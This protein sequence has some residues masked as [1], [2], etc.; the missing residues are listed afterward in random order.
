M[1]KPSAALPPARV[2][3]ETTGTVT[4]RHG[5]SIVIG[6]GT[7]WCA[8]MFGGRFHCDRR[9]VG[10]LAAAPG[11]LT[12]LKPWDGPDIAGAAYEIRYRNDHAPH[13]V[14][15]KDAMAVMAPHIKVTP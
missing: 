8:D 2:Q 13:V 15:I 11:S 1:H 4:L 12:L 3:A 5:S 7:A 9:S 14:A 6:A 10:I